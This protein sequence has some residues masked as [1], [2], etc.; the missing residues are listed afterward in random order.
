MI[1]HIL[2]RKKI[3]H[4]AL[5]LHLDCARNSLGNP[6]QKQILVREFW[7]SRISRHGIERRGYSRIPGRG[8]D[9]RP[10]GQDSGCALERG[11][12]LEIWAGRGT[13]AWA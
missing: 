13:L 5:L 4:K 2:K 6:I 7:A 11:W 9:V 3:E 12:L 1:V 8:R 10:D